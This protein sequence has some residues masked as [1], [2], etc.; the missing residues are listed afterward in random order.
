MSNTPNHEPRYDVLWPLSRKAVKKSAAKKLTSKPVEKAVKAPVKAVKVN[1]KKAQS[2]NADLDMIV[3]SL[4]KVKLF[5]PL[6]S[7]FSKKIVAQ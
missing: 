3:Q 7:S 6:M 4:H 1:S 5:L 2:D